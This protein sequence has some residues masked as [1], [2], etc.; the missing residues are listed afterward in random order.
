[1][2]VENVPKELGMPSRKSISTGR[3]DWEGSVLAFRGK[4]WE[5]LCWQGGHQKRITLRPD[6]TAVPCPGEVLLAEALCT[7]QSMK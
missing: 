6:L 1:M 7:L 3:G 5:R 4:C 2:E